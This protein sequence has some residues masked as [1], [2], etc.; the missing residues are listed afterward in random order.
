MNEMD[1]TSHLLRW[2]HGAPFRLLAPRLEYRAGAWRNLTGDLSTESLLAG[3]LIWFKVRSIGADG[4][5]QDDEVHELEPKEGDVFLQ[6]SRYQE[7]LP[8]LIWR[9]ASVSNDDH[10]LFLIEDIRDGFVAEQ[11]SETNQSADPAGLFDRQ[12]DSSAEKAVDNEDELQRIGRCNLDWK[13][14]WSLNSGLELDGVTNPIADHLEISTG[15]MMTGLSSFHG[16]EV[17]GSLLLRCQVRDGADPIG[18]PTGIVNA[19]AMAARDRG[20]VHLLTRNENANQLGILVCQVRPSLFEGYD[21]AMTNFS[22]DKLMPRKKGV[23]CLD[24]LVDECCSR[25][26]SIECD[27]EHAKS[28]VDSAFVLE[29]IHGF[30]LCQWPYF[31]VGPPGKLKIIVDANSREIVSGIGPVEPDSLASAASTDWTTWLGTDD[32]MSLTI[33]QEPVSMEL[34]RNWLEAFLSGELNW[35]PWIQKE[36]EDFRLKGYI[37]RDEARFFEEFGFRF[38]LPQEGAGAP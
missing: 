9:P 8:D 20:E 12:S 6:L 28:K 11:P 25:D 29:F 31:L 26:V 19:I 24:G 38:F 10:G 35:I 14:R 21:S 37:A 27:I 4:Q 13:D 23:I 5:P 30:R 18:C 3:E 15:D 2:L 17:A 7:D 36:G 22:T 32:A 33:G 1:F 16:E 34:S